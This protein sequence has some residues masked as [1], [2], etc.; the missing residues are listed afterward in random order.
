[1]KK[2]LRPVHELQSCDVC[3]RTILKGERTETYLAPAGERYSVCELCFARAEQSGWLRESAHGDTPPRMPNDEPRRPLLG[4][5]MRR[6]VRSEPGPALVGEQPEQ[7]ES[8]QAVEEA[9]PTELGQAEALEAQEDESEPEPPP[10]PP[11][12]PAGDVGSMIAR[13]RRLRE[14][15]EREQRRSTAQ[16]TPGSVPTDAVQPRFRSGQ[17]V[18]C[19]PYGEGIV[20]SAVIT[21]GRERLTIDFP[22]HGAIQVD[23]AVNAVRLVDEQEEH[24]GDSE[25]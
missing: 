2:E 5:L 24:A 4:R 3:G 14:E 17:H 22:D 25:E 7:A 13:M 8:H 16:P 9:Q 23:P 15:R 1:V 12:E 19:V 18:R 20:Q 6:G 21:D 10:E 11:R